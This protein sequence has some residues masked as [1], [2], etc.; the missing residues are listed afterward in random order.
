MGRY[1][2]PRPR[3]TPY[4]SWRGYQELKDEEKEL[5]SRRKETVKALSAAAAEGDR[6]ENAEY[7]YRKKELYGIDARIRYLQKRLPDLKIVSELPTDQSKVY[8][9]ANIE[10]LDSDGHR[11]RYLL[12]GPDEVDAINGVI[13][14]DAPIAK[15]ILGK[16]VGDSFCFESPKGEQEFEV[17]A[18]DYDYLIKE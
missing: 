12:A 14:I 2:P 13:S 5:W 4:I 18:I 1:R 7:I 10:L 3:Q 15:A 6:S 8:F 9:G 17:I 11:Y 16:E